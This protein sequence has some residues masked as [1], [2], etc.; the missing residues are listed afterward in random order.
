MLPRLADDIGPKEFQLPFMHLLKEPEV[1]T[2]T[3]ARARAAAELLSGRQQKIV[4]GNG[5]HIEVA[6]SILT[7]VLANVQKRPPD[8]LRSATLSALMNTGEEEKVDSIEATSSIGLSSA[9]VKKAADDSQ[10]MDTT[11]MENLDRMLYPHPPPGELWLHRALFQHIGLD[12]NQ[13]GI[14]I[15]ALLS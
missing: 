15:Q 1:G 5:F 6:A 11:V 9:D 12:S 13:S 4:A 10:D 3:G 14:C 8:F 7:F 2:G